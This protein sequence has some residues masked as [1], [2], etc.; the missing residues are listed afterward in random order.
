MNGDTQQP[1][2]SEPGS[3][4]RPVRPV[5]PENTLQRESELNTL[6]SVSEP[7]S[8]LWGVSMRAWLSVMIIGT[9]CAQCLSETLIALRNGTSCMVEEPLYSMAVMALGFY[10]GQ[11]TSPPAA[12]KP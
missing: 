6:H 10:F 12:Q 3:M 8:M 5:F 9:V 2:T 4:P 7:G 11:K 1:S